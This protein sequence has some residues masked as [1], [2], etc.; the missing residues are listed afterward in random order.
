MIRTI[1]RICPLLLLLGVVGTSSSYGGIYHPQERFEFD[2]DSQGHA[3]AI[4]Y[5]N[6]FASMILELRDVDRAD[7]PGQARKRRLDRIDE[8]LPIPN[9]TPEQN[10]TLIGDLIRLGRSSET[11][12]LIGSQTG[13]VNM[14]YAIHRDAQKGE[15]QR[16]YEQQREL[17]R[18]F[19]KALFKYAP[20]ELAWMKRLEEQ[21]HLGFLF[22]RSRQTKTVGL[23]ASENVDPIFPYVK[24]PKG[25][26][27]PVKFIGESGKY[28]P[29]QIAPTE[30]AKLP[31]DAIA[32]VQQLLM[33]YP[34]DDRLFW[35]LGELY[36]ANGEVD[37][38]FDI[39]DRLT[40]AVG[41]TP[42]ILREHRSILARYLDEKDLERKATQA[43]EEKAREEE[44]Q[45]KQRDA[46]REKVNEWTYIAIAVG[47]AVLLIY[48]QGKEILRR[49]FR[50]KKK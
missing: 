6:G 39:F 27:D 48:F 37:I 50:R 40:N 43:A 3:K 41:Y 38:A 35:L 1:C 21:Y 22:A 30:K 18:M 33:W 29:G 44:L 15:W 45:R 26:A 13:F 4:Q 11:T 34:K 24:P 28:E 19:P 25:N 31:P 10:A 17:V 23:D 16:A 32:I 5:Q 46:Q 14:A 7:Y 2:L 47:I 49:V 20:D 42:P 9:R 12:R 8:L 36:N